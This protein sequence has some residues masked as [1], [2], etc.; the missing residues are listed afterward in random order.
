MFEWIDTQLVKLRGAN[1]DRK[2][3][4]AFPTFEAAKRAEHLRISLRQFPTGA[5]EEEVHKLMGE[6]REEVRAKFA[7]PIVA[8]ENEV[9]R[10]GSGIAQASAELVI[11]Q[12][13][14]KSELDPLYE[15]LNV[16]SIETKAAQD[17]KQKSYAD[18]E[19]AKERIN[20]WHNKSKRSPFL[21][22]NGGTALPRY[23]LFGQSLG[24][25]EGYK[26]DKSSASR[27]IVR[28]KAQ[29]AKLNERR[30]EIH[31]K[32]S[33][34]KAAR[35]KMFDL[36]EQGRSVNSLQL[37]LSRQQATLLEL[38]SR[39]AGLRTERGNALDAAR[40]RTGAFEIERLILALKLKRDDFVKS[41]DEPDVAAAR[42]AAHVEDWINA[43][44]S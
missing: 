13:S 24:D 31:Q 37:S 26:A 12:H 30:G 14:Y 16:L 29:I 28:L 5:L 41:F 19:K 6:V 33:V 18:L 1:R 40:Y 4:L 22:G 10:I 39:L 43:H 8:L 42:F 38:A 11:L 35:Q 23:S 44:G 36:K 7:G 9:A 20:S 21:F 34:I 27:D 25:L 3:R 17:E 2:I 32:I 15:Q